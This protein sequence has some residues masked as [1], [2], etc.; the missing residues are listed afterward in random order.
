MAS[1][2]TLIDSTSEATARRASCRYPKSEGVE[3][4][5]LIY[6]D[7][8]TAMLFAIAE[9]RVNVRE[10]PDLLDEELGGEEG[11]AVRGH[12]ASPARAGWHDDRGD[13]AA[14]RPARS[15]PPHCV[16]RFR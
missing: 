9:I 6:R 11:L 1:G 16:S 12:P 2:L 3:A 5:P 13:L 7:E 4:K 15:A 10:I 8:V 14:A